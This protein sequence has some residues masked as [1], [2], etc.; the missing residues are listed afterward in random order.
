MIKNSS[1]QNFSEIISIDP[2]SLQSY[3][4]CK[5]EIK[6]FELEKSS[7]NSFFISF[8]DTKNVINDTI[9][10]SRN[11][12]DSSLVDA[13]EIKVYDELGLDSTVAYTITYFEIETDDIK[14]RIF[15]IFAIS[16]ALIKSKLS[17]IAEKIDYIDYVTTTP[18][19]ISSLYKQAFL[20]LNSTDCFIYFQKDDA[21]LSI[22]KNG[23]YLYLKSLN[24]SLDELFKKFCEL[25]GEKIDKEDFYALLTTEKLTSKNNSYKSFLTQL[26]D[27]LFLHINDVIIFAKRSYN[28]ESIDKIYIGSD[29]GIFID[30][31]EYVKNYLQLEF[32]EFNFNITINSQQHV[33]QLHVLM[34]LA[35]Q[36]YLEN[37]DD[38]LNFTIFKR[39]PPFRQRPVGKLISVITASIILFIAYPTYQ[40]IYAKLLQVHV[41][42]TTKEY[43]KIYTEAN[44]I[45][46]KIEKLKK[47][48]IKIVNLVKKESDK[49]EFRRKLL[50]EIYKKKIDS[51]M[52]AIMLV[53]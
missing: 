39:P 4:Y 7:K 13:I 40:Y 51:S 14:N 20:E 53:E 49:L 42:Q 52:K 22:Y 47:E 29:I 36:V 11:I 26:F 21:F 6:P 30:I 3:M 35:S 44:A 41:K 45:R 2:K 48:K 28:I 5:N 23:E 38:K 31:N 12:P 33:N 15:N 10:I 9:N 18:F 24:Y 19:L 8:V 43:K 25:I 46:I 16:S 27:E 37:R 17:K 34:I 50:N 1:Q 32:N